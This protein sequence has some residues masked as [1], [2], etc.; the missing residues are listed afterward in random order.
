MTKRKL[1]T[2]IKIHR[3]DAYYRDRAKYVGKRV[4]MLGDWCKWGRSLY[5]TLSAETLNR[6]ERLFFY[7]VRIKP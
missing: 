6:K 2:I 3:L 4:A 7:K 1:V 5:G